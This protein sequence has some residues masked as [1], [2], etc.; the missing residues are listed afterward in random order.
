MK[1][2]FLKWVVIPLSTGH[3]I[4]GIRARHAGAPLSACSHSTCFSLCL[5]FLAWYIR[6]NFALA[7]LF[8]PRGSPLLSSPSPSEHA[9]TPHLALASY[10]WTPA[11]R[12]PLPCSLNQCG[13]TTL[14]FLCGAWDVLIAYPAPSPDAPHHLL[15]LHLTLTSEIRP[16]LV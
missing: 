1:V 10:R 13:H 16:V 9:V 7:H 15:N 6:T 11:W 3:L 2:F 14:H 5:R 4:S 12:V 8:L